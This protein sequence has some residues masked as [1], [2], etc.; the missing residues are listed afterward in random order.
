MCV[1]SGDITISTNDAIH[2]LRIL[3]RAKS[4]TGMLIDWHD[5]NEDGE[6]PSEPPDPVAVSERLAEIDSDLMNVVHRIRTVW[7]D[8]SIRAASNSRLNT[9]WSERREANVSA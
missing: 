7:L 2:L 8:A 1:L 5:T 4:N 9:S 6:Y 3:R